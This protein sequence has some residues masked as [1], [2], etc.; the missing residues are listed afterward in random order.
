MGLT[1]HRRH[2]LQAAMGGAVLARAPAVFAQPATPTRWA[3]LAPG[4]T[5]LM[6]PYIAAKNLSEKFG[7]NL[8]APTEYTTVSTYYNDFAAGNYDVCI[9]SWDVFAAR[10]QAGVPIRLLCT[11]T[12]ADMIM[13]L[14][15]DKAINTIEDLRGKT[16]AAGQSTGTY[17]MVSGLIK[18]RYKLEVG[19]DIAVQGVDNPAAAMTLVMANR[20]DAGLSWEPSVSAALKRRP[21]LRVIFSAGQAYR[22]LANSTLPYFGVGVREDWAQR[23]PDAVHRVREVFAACI[24]GIV[25]DPVDAAR[26]AGSATGFTPDVISDALTSKRLSFRYGSMTD[27]AEREAMIAAGAFML[28]NGLLSKPIDQGF[29][30]AS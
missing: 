6:A 17:R 3:Y 28:R 12:T 10:Y 23:N 8:A 22:E 11:I 24:A 2:L 18:E 27:P 14:T 5:A 25:A 13:I 30:I 9:G 20:A 7:A 1:L 21:D 4:F 16:L 19:K 29:F 15:G 26:V